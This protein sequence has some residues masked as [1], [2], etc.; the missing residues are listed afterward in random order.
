MRQIA[1]VEYSFNTYC[2]D[3]DCRGKV[4][5]IND[6]K[7]E[8][9]KVFFSAPANTSMAFANITAHKL[10][11]DEAALFSST[12]NRESFRK[13]TQGENLALG[14]K[15]SFIPKPNYELTA[16]DDIAETILTD[17]KLGLA[18]DMLW[19]NTNAVAWFYYTGGET[20]VSIILDLGA[21][22]PIKKA[23]NHTKL[24]GEICN[25]CR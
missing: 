12:A 22:Q 9:I 11:K 23:V 7:I 1:H 4:F 13:K 21:V 18:N 15:L 16:K 6:P 24:T 19:F 3:W 2:A 20:F 25:A 5:D 17:G 14:K 10:S 8:F